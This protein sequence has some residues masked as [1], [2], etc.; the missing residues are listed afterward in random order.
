VRDEGEWE[1]TRTDPF[2]G[3][4]DI[5]GWLQNLHYGIALE[6]EWMNRKWNGWIPKARWAL[7]FTLFCVE[8]Y[9]STLYHHG[10][11]VLNERWGKCMLRAGRALRSCYI[12]FSI[13]PPQIASYTTLLSLMPSNQ[14]FHW[15]TQSHLYTCS[16]YPLAHSGMMSPPAW[17]GNVSLI[18]SKG[19][20]YLPLDLRFWYS[21]FV[22]LITSV[23]TLTLQKHK[24]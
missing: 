22:S 3:L 7:N 2:R 6:V 18:Q 19:K 16:A 11:D 9:K 24:R 4:Y 17:N 14:S 15:A 13:I 8:E 20:C 12:Y 23:I 10:Q 5:L 1:V 21:A